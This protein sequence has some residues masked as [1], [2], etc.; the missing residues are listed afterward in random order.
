MGRI[1]FAWEMGGNLGHIAR[2]LPLAIACRE[3]GHDV[4]YAAKDLTAC[5]DAARE[6]GIDF[7]QAPVMRAKPARVGASAAI[8]YADLLWQTGFSDARALDAVLLGWQGLFRTFKPDAVV[9]DFAPRALLAARLADIPVLL[10]GNGFETPPRV[11]P[12]PSF[13]PWQQM[14]DEALLAAEERVVGRINDVLAT[15]GK[16][17]IDKLWHLYAESPLLI[18]YDPEFDH[19]G[20]RP[21]ATYVGTTTRLPNRA[22]DVAWK[23]TGK[24]IVVYLRAEIDGVANVL[25]AL[26]ELEA[27]A[28]C[29]VPDMPSEWRAQF[30]SLRFFDR[31]VNLAALLPQAD[32]VITHGSGAVADAVSAGVPV[33][34]VPG[35]TEQYLAGLRAEGQD[36][37]VVLRKDRSKQACAGAIKSLLGAPRFTAATRAFAQRA[38]RLVGRQSVTEQ[39][40][41]IESLMPSANG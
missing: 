38:N 24:R 41:A 27:D 13:R 5:T 10:L 33:L 30:A 28:I 32:L 21:E 4:L 11:S 9:Y 35:V 22:D 15:R 34:V 14:P 19:F 8:N 23:A 20:P 17:P 31:P 2:D 16:R 39:I 36:F 3:A 6:F 18:A 12:L 37:G 26:Q 40:H 1:L 7:V 25:A 29:I